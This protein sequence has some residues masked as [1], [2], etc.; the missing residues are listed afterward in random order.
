M[1]SDPCHSRQQLKAQHQ[2]E[3]YGGIDTHSDTI[4]SRWSIRSDRG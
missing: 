1:A 4:M 3:V 2:V